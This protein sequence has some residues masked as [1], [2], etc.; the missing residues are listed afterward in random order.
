LLNGSGCRIGRM[1]LGITVK[2]ARQGGSV[3]WCGGTGVQEK[4]KEP[5]VV[6]GG[7]DRGK[8]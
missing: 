7:A 4:K 5:A 1:G 3:D 8:G 6:E 2:A